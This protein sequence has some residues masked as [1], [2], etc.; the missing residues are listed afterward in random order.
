M[1]TGEVIT[2]RIWSVCTDFLQEIGIVK[3]TP[4][5]GTKML[6][7]HRE[8]VQILVAE[9]EKELAVLRM[10]LLGTCLEAHLNTNGDYEP[11]LES[12]LQWFRDV[13]TMDKPMLRVRWIEMGL[14]PEMAKEI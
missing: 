9:R 6:V 2:Q 3:K 12:L 5:E 14:S 13:I 4:K 11:G 8:A 1:K 10:E 7:T